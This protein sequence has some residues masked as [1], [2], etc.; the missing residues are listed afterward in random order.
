MALETCFFYK[1]VKGLSP[2]YLTSYLQ[3][4]NN[5]IYQ[6]QQSTAKNIVKQTAF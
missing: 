5:K 4:H 6:T 2:K 1:I 3:L